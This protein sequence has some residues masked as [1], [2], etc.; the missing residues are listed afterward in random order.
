[1]A[2][3]LAHKIEK[4][5]EPILKI[6]Y[7]NEIRCDDLKHMYDVIIPNVTTCI[8]D[9]NFKLTNY[10]R[11]SSYKQYGSDLI[12]ATFH[13]KKICDNNIYCLILTFGHYEIEMF[14]NVNDNSVSLNHYSS[15]R[16]RV[17]ANS[18]LLSGTIKLFNTIH[19]FAKK[20]DNVLSFY[21][22]NFIHQDIV[23]LIISYLY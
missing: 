4:M 10:N 22:P 18:I 20:I 5:V 13:Y 3:D 11:S 17:I 23:N 1:M 6:V 12:K 21:N 15:F 14:L 2:T 9:F 19:G 7:E 16:D 8:F